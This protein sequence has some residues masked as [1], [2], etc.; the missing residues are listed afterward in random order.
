MS[1]KYEQIRSLPFPA[2][3]TA[4]GLDLSRFKHVKDEWRGACPVHNPKQNITSFNYNDDGRF[5]CFSCGAKGR[6]SIDLVKLVR[7]VQ[8]QAAVELLSAAPAVEPPKAKSPSSGD[9]GAD[10]ELKPFK[11]S[12]AKF[13]VPCPWLQQRIPDQAIRELYGVFCYSNVT[14][15]SNVNGDVLIPVKDVE[16]VLYGY[17]ARNTGEVTPEHPKYWFPPGVPKSRFLFGADVIRAGRFGHVP[18]KFVYLVESPFCVMKFAMYGLPAVSPFG[19]SVSQE[20]IDILGKIAKGVVYLPDRDK[21]D[22]GAHRLDSLCAKLWL[23]FP[24]LPD[25]I[26]DPEHLDK[27]QILAL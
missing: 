14:R 13:A 22:Q 24:Q 17:L 18:A 26:D 5:G 27:N 25:G 11:G 6:G 8:F 4:L 7:G 20:Q 1:D 16:G 9:S 23:R 19:W 15:K 3:A 21:R 10:G 2:L 12:Y